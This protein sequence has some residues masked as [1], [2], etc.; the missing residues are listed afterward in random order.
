MTNDSLQALVL[1]N[2]TTAIVL[3]DGDA[4]ILYLNQAAEALLQASGARCRGELLQSVFNESEADESG[5]PNATRNRGAFTKRQ[6][7]LTLA[8]G[9]QIT[10]D[11]TVTPIGNDLDSGFIIEIQPLD[12]WIRI[13]REDAMKSSHQMTNLMVRGLAHEI[14]NPLGGLRGAAQLLAR[15]LP[16]DDLK[17][18]THVIIE[19]ADRLRGLVDRLMGSPQPLKSEALNIHQVTERVRQLIEAENIGQLKLDVDYDPSIPELIGD[20]AQ[21]IQALLNVVRNAT[22]ALQAH[23]PTAGDANILIRS[24]AQRR[25][26]IGDIQHRLVCRIDVQDNGP[27][28]DP[29][30][31]DR[32]FFP[33]I[34]GRPEGTGLGLAIAQSIL[35]HHGGSIECATDEQ[36]TTFSLY[37][38]MER[39]VD[40]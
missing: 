23:P 20:R 40:E 6:A 34:S 35:N 28:I 2:L 36:F 15:E 4:R 10:V 24:R 8:T 9:S 5:M 39:N 27:G 25:Y 32:I 11:Y 29:E 16:S 30:L 17:D 18:Y 7:E 14:K 12:R 38:P 26:T 3:V 21:L 37:L 33:M 31:V 22:Q 19:E 1:D 13:S